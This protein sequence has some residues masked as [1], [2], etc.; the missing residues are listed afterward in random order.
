M[1]QINFTPKKYV[2]KIYSNIIIAKLIVVGIILIVVLVFVSVLH[3]T[4]YKSLKLEN[5]NFVRE[6]KLLESQVILSRKI[7][8]DIKKVENYI[9][10]IEKL[11]K[12]RYNYVAFMQD[13][14]NNLPA[15][16][17]FSGI[18]TRTT[19]DFIEVKI[20]VNSNSL[21]DLLWWFSYI[22]SN[23]KRYSD[24]KIAAINYSFDYYTTQ[25]SYKYKYEI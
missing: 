6:Y 25:I 3:Y 21:E 1:I 23:K 16:V 10:Q 4:K 19:S 20:N 22:D 12:N 18:D 17:W 11:N 24:A 14:V 5:E 13:L 9:F 7:E 15:T 2:E 8:D